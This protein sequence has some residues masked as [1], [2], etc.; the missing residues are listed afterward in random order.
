MKSSSRLSAIDLKSVGDSLEK[1][2]SEALAQGIRR[3]G[4]NIFAGAERIPLLAESV[5][6]IWPV[7]VILVVRDSEIAEYFRRLSGKR[8]Q[9]SGVTVM[10]LQSYLETPLQWSDGR[11]I[12]V[13]DIFDLLLASQYHSGGVGALVNRLFMASYLLGVSQSLVM[14]SM[15][16]GNQIKG[17][18]ITEGYTETLPLKVLIQ[19]LQ[20]LFEQLQCFG[21]GVPRISFRVMDE[22][23][24]SVDPVGETLLPV[25]D[26]NHGDVLLIWK[27][28]QMALR[29][30]VDM[31]AWASSMGFDSRVAWQSRKVSQS[32]GELIHTD[33]RTPV[34]LAREGRSYRRIHTVLIGY[35]PCVPVVFEPPD[36]EEGIAELRS[37]I[38]GEAVR[39][40]MV[41]HQILGALRTDP[42]AVVLVRKWISASRRKFMAHLTGE[43]SGY[44][45]R[46]FNVR[47]K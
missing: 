19:P 25:I 18:E 40:L 14:E 16:Q 27:S 21:S 46:K 41:K 12:L 29:R 34:P 45:G 30:C 24:G 15:A 42:E 13:D 31:E 36:G 22:S 3:L 8:P 23:E 37:G 5:S 10:E 11:G 20:G 7:E 4:L 39:A 35:P 9:L 26:A 6:R 17:A 28:D 38:T 44:S 47:A 32:R 1:V 33:C 2:L 43:A